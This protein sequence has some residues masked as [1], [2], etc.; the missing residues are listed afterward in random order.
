MTA[1]AE[2]GNLATRPDALR[3]NRTF[4]APLA[5]VWRMWQSRDHM[6]RWWGPE[7]FTCVELDWELTPERPWRATMASKAYDRRVSRMG[8]IVREVDAH[9]R[10][11]FT[12]AWD[13]DSGHDLDTVIT[14]TFTETAAGTVQGFYQAPFSTPAIR[15][16]HVGGWN[17]LF[18][19][20]QLYV[21]NLAIADGKGIRT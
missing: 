9:E 12:F 14:V 13:E 11:V 18:N 5:L 1:D 7:S 6:I 17:S 4:E 19:K 3:L 8:G 20:Q 2:H 10:I 21:E 16:S 15:D